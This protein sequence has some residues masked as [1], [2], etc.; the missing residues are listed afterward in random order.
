MPGP[1]SDKALPGRTT[2][3]LPEQNAHRDEALDEEEKILSGHPDVNMPALLT[4][5]VKGG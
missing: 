3:P 5:D 1:R 2:A 4:R